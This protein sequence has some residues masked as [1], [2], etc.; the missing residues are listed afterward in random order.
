MC[1]EYADA[2]FGWVDAEYSWV[3]FLRG[4]F[5]VYDQEND[6]IWMGESADCGSD[7]VPI[8]ENGEVPQLPGCE[9]FYGV[10]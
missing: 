4:A 2:T 1:A 6:G 3:A 10:F 5:V 7:I 9:C 8:T